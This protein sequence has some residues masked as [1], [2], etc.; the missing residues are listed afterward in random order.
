MSSPNS[1]TLTAGVKPDEERKYYRSP[2][3]WLVILGLC[4]SSFLALLEA[5]IVSNA[6]PTIVNSLHGEDYVWVGSAYNLAA[7]AFMPSTGVLAQMFGR[8]SVLVGALAVFSLGC[9]LCGAAQTMAMLIGGRVVQGIGGAGILSVSTIIISDVVPL[10]DR[11]VFNGLLQLTWCL[12]SGLG[13]V[14]GGT[15]AQNGKW[16]WIFYL[17]LP[18]APIPSIL[19]ATCLN[20]KVPRWTWSE[21]WQ[22]FD[23]LGN[24]LV[25]SGS[26]LFAIG[27]TWG[28][29]AKFP[30]DSAS[31]IAPL[32][33]GGV[34][35]LAFMLYEYRWSPSPM[36]P[37]KLMLNRTTL[38]GYLQ[39]MIFPIPFLALVYYLPIY[40]QACKGLSPA[41]SGVILFGLAFSTP[42]I[43]IISGI[44][45]TITKRYR[46]QLWLGWVISI[47]G[48]V[49][50]GTTHTDTSLR[51]FV[52]FEILVGAG[53]GII[54][55]STYFPVLAPLPLTAA[56][57]ALA[58]FAFLR[59]FFQ[60]WGIT[61]GGVILQNTF[62]GRI[63]EELLARLPSNLDPLTLIPLLRE[64]SAADLEITRIAFA[65]SLDRVWQVM[66]GVSGAGLLVSCFTR[67]YELHTS[68]DKDW[69]V[70]EKEK[71]VPSAGAGVE[72]EESPAAAQM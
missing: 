31:V 5:T 9:A 7:A 3:F 8:K 25:I 48:L 29:S 21:S 16:R 35:L 33:I 32:C 6:L 17:N 39:V 36:V 46:A 57:H 71:D 62:P 53:F 61:V 65:D 55:S 1:E 20:L 43:A 34:I 27:L 72:R 51:T 67:H 70:K 63:P 15:L 24:L 22:H 50:M 18:I 44:I 37:V 49:L 69:G 13:P 60:I 54:F 56:A 41:R 23:A 14:V 28:G 30:W 19:V 10:S 4:I 11:G 40:L 38:S 64:L 52:G 45:I 66:A 26:S 68:T 47:V 2:S 12:A 42:P 58:F 59:Q